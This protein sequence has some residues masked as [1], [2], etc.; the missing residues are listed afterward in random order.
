MAVDLG[1]LREQ[2]TWTAL[3]GLL[4]LFTFVFTQIFPP[5]RLILKKRNLRLGVV[6]YVQLSHFLGNLLLGL[7]LDIHNTG[8]FGIVVQRIKCVLIGPR[9]ELD[10]DL[11][12][13]RYS[14][15]STDVRT[16]G[17]IWV[18][19]EEHWSG[20]VIFSRLLSQDQQ[21]ASNEI[22][23]AI[24]TDLEKEQ[25]IVSTNVSNEEELRARNSAL[26]RLA[27]DRKM[28]TDSAEA[29]FRTQ[30][31]I[32]EGNYKLI[33]GLISDDQKLKDARAFEFTVFRNHVQLLEL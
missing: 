1:F 8:G 18:N 26:Q 3:V 20:D 17:E 15:S 14:L 33:V 27:Q 21:A 6:E 11:T 30:F 22:M 24:R 4:A 23:S 25:K 31:N 28:H 10:K 5:L 13:Y 7:H 19:Y 29:F 16:L 2:W 9:P 32:V 12:A